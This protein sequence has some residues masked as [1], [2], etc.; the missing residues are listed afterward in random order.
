LGFEGELPAGVLVNRDGREVKI[1]RG[2]VSEAALSKA[3]QRLL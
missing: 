3:I 2:A 1:I